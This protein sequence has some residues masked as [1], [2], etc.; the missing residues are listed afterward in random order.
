MLPVVLVIY[1]REAY[2]FK[3]DHS[4]RVTF[5]KQLRCISYPRTNSFF[6]DTGSVQV[7]HNNF[8]LEVKSNSGFPVWMI[9]VISKLNVKREAL[10]KYTLSIDA[11]KNQLNNYNQEQVIAFAQP[12]SSYNNNMN[13]RIP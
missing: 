3:F 5:D 1:E 8:I 7:Y 13:Y 9:D 4:T 2:L 6:S 11:Q 10:S 12:L